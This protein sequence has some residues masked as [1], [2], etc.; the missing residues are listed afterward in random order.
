MKIGIECEGRLKG[1]P[2]LFCDAT[3][4]LSVR[5]VAQD[6]QVSHIYVSDPNNMLSYEEV[7]SELAEF[8]VTLDVTAITLGYR[9]SN[10][11]IMLSLPGY[12]Q[13]S[14][15]TDH[16]QIKFEHERNVVVFPINSA[17][18]TVP[19]DFAGDVDL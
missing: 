6:M 15:L 11:S 17:L 9:P 16:D 13:I 8:M 1:I 5:N 19:A 4:L 7:G 3:E 10:L 12:D 14:K 18:L 2:T